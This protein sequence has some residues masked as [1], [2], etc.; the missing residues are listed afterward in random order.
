VK[1]AVAALALVGCGGGSEC[2]PDEGVVARVVDGD[3][4][5]L[6]SGLKVRYLM[7]DTPETT[8][9]KNECF[10]ANAAQFNSDLVLGKTVQLSYDVECEDRFGRT[11]AYVT[12]GGVEVNTLMVERGFGC[13]LHIPP[14]GD[15]RAA[16]FEALEDAAKAD[17]K[18]MWGAC[19]SCHCDVGDCPVMAD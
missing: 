13:V 1:L 9:G 4:I 19:G 8:G 7:M 16:E 18:G 15:D 11:L 3:T 12:V 5:E 2:G 14:N 6:E 10:G 17:S